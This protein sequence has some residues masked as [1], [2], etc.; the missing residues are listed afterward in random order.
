MIS[1]LCRRLEE[2]RHA[3]VDQRLLKSFSHGLIWFFTVSEIGVGRVRGSVSVSSLFY[4]SASTGFTS[5]LILSIKGLSIEEVCPV[6]LVLSCFSFNIT[7][8]S[9][10]F[11]EFPSRNKFSGVCDLTPGGCRLHVQWRLK[12]GVDLGQPRTQMAKVFV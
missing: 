11:F 10:Q 4:I 6:E 9:H 5:H 3:D 2:R 7:S 1:V 8:R 12:V